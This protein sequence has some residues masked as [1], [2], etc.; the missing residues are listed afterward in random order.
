MSKFDKKSSQKPPVD[1]LEAITTIEQYARN[2]SDRKL[3]EEVYK[4]FKR[5]TNSS[6]QVPMDKLTFVQGLMAYEKIL[7]EGVSPREALEALK[8]KYG[9]TQEFID[10]AKDNPYKTSYKDGK[11]TSTSREIVKASDSSQKQKDMIKSGTFNRKAISAAKTPNQQLHQLKKS[12]DIHN[13]VEKLEEEVFIHEQ[14]L[15]DNEM[16]IN[17]LKG[18]V[19]GNKD[20]SLDNKKKNARMY[21]DKGYTYK[22]IANHYGCNI[23]TVKRWLKDLKEEKK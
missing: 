2:T 4:K 9:L 21:K 12:V 11:A 18:E 16:A 7:E 6:K 19:L 5:A 14:R 3:V 8:E 20:I 10:A 13:R 22:E 23:S 1:V 17:D 15:S